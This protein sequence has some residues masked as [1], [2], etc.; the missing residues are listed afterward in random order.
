MKVFKVLESFENP[1][2]IRE[3][4]NIAAHSFQ[5]A[6][7]VALEAGYDISSLVEIIHDDNG[8]L[9]TK[10][11][12][13][14]PQEYEFSDLVIRAIRDLQP[15]VVITLYKNAIGDLQLNIDY[16]CNNNNTTLPFGLQR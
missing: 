7:Q 11:K 14:T 8:E 10:V 6:K 4:H 15:G 2:E 16:G 1:E 3:K 13:L 5:E 12:P 9:T